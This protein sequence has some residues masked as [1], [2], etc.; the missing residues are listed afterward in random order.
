MA[1]QNAIAII[2]AR[3]GS[4]RI[5][6]KNVQPLNGIPLITYTIRAAKESGIF[7][8]ILVSSDDDEILEIAAAEGVVA[9]R[10]SEYLAADNVTQVEVLKEIV[11]R[12]NLDQEV[13]VSLLPTCPFRTGIDI[14]ESYEKFLREEPDALISVCPY[15]FPVQFALEEKGGY[16]SK[17]FANG[18]QSTQSQKAKQH[19]HP[20]GAI[21]MKRSG[22]FKELPSFFEGKVVPYMM[23]VEKSIDIDYPYQLQ[24]A[25]ILLKNQK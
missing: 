22:K 8:Q 5:P 16:L 6:R 7:S 12:F 18:Y 17:I 13:L 10:R 2:P 19:L 15:E 4:K 11:N 3:G 21:Y 1:K 14:R 24:L 25:E 20:N 9:D 23:T